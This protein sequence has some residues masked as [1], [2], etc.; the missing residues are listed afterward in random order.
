MKLIHTSDIHLDSPLTSHLS[1]RGARERKRELISSF[2]KMTEDAAREGVS[3]IIIAGDL[4]DS[5]RV[6]T[7]TLTQVLGIIENAR[8]ISFLYLPGN[9]E[10]DRL[11]RGD[12]VLP[13]NLLIFGKEWTYFR[14]GDVTI[15]GR[16]ETTAGMFSSLALDPRDKNIVVLHGELTDRSD[17]GGRIGTR[18]IQ[19]LPIDYLA[20]GH[21]HFYSAKKLSERCAAVYCGTPEGRGFDE[22]GDKGYVMLEV[23]PYDIEH[24]FRKRAVRTLHTINVD[25]SG[26]DREIE[27]ENRVAYEISRIPECDLVRVILTGEHEVELRRDTDAICDRFRDRFFYIEVKDA[28]RLKISSDDYKN[29][30]SLKGEF[31]RLVLSDTA[32][33]DDEKARIIECGIRTLS[34]EEPI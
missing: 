24:S 14:L 6:S 9:H 1:E 12:A 20:L 17:T 4:F 13:E 11:M 19:S 31:I 22:T 10:G 23:T 7:R 33:T 15:A 3:G 32:L 29:D 30:I 16:C 2:R 28:S 26:A 25:I 8:G 27:V 21:Y 18:D 5:E 34:G